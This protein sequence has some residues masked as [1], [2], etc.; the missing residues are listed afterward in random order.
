M[1]QDHATRIGTITAHRHNR[2]FAVELDDGEMIDA[3]VKSHTARIM[4]RI[5][6]GDR[7]RVRLPAVHGQHGL[8]LGHHHD[9]PNGND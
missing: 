9:D 2:I 3:N 7:V 1:N 5:V 4:F 6:P 8:I